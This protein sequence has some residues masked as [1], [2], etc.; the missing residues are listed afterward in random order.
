[1]D[2]GATVTETRWVYRD[3]VVEVVSDEPEEIRDEQKEALIVK[4]FIL[5]RERDY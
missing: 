2:G 5:R 3:Y 1:M 4:H